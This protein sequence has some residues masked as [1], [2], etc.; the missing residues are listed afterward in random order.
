MRQCLFDYLVYL[1]H[2]SI[3]EVE[4]CVKFRQCGKQALWAY[5]HLLIGAGD[6]FERV[7]CMLVGR[8]DPAPPGPLGR[9]LISEQPS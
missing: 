2:G 4:S 3:W 9:Q 8:L 1:I 5:D 6:W 7:Q